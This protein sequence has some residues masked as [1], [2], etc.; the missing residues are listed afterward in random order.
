LINGA[1]GSAFQYLI[2]HIYDE[3][4]LINKLPRPDRPGF[5]PIG[6]KQFVFAQ[7]YVSLPFSAFI[8]GLKDH[9]IRLPQINNKNHL[10]F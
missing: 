2:N 3:F 8:H 7:K 1:I 5:S 9:G 10:I 6:S 4:M